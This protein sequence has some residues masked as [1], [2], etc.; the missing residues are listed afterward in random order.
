MTS[1]SQ[2]HP[3]SFIKVPSHGQHIFYDHNINFWV[4]EFQ[5]KHHKDVKKRAKGQHYFPHFPSPSVLVYNIIMN[6][7]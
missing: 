5:E 6:F 2:G 4:L 7:E 1:N 3:Q